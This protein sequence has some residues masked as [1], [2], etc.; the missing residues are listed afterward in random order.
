MSFLYE[1]F[2]TL[3]VFKDLQEEEK[4]N[5]RNGL[6]ASDRTGIQQPHPLIFT[7]HNCG[8]YVFWW[9]Y[10]L[11]RNILKQSVVIQMI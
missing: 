8:N 7:V 5:Y 1:Y 2:N 9:H 10:I 6:N 3:F 11:T 4:K